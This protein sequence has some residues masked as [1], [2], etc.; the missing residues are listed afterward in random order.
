MS[1]GIQKALLVLSTGEPF[2]IGTRPIPRPGPGQVVVKVEATAL[3]IVD[4]AMQRLGLFVQTWPTVLGADG[5]GTVHELGVG[6]VN[7]QK[8]DRVLFQRMVFEADRGTFQEYALADANRVSKIPSN[9]TFDQAST[10]PLCLATAT[11]GLYAPKAQKGGPGGAGLTPPWMDG[12]LGKYKDQPA[13]VI[14][15]S[16]AVGQFAIQLLKLSGFNPIISTASAHNFDY[17]K[18]AGATHVIDYHV[19]PYPSLPAIVAQITSDPISIV[20]DA[21]SSDDSQRAGW[22]ILAP[23]GVIAVVSGVVKPVVVGK[24]GEDAEDGKHVAAVRGNVDLV[25]KDVEFGNKM[26]ASL[27]GLLEGGG[28]KPC[29]VELLSG[30]LTAVEGGLERIVKKEVSGVKLVVRPQETA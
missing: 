29:R 9:I 5:A 12:G 11:A 15:G 16:S 1:S 10:I 7:V 18:A 8:G 24:A 25:T 14:G 17:V 23:K 26:Y 28:L 19:T 2:T 20:Y 3:N 27:T 6:V 30:G 4:F 21:I 22:E 13:L